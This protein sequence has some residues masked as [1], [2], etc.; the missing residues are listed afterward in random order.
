MPI[1]CQY[2]KNCLPQAQK[3]ET[4]TWNCHSFPEYFSGHLENAFQQ[5]SCLSCIRFSPLLFILMVKSQLTMSRIEVTMRI[6]NIKAIFIKRASKRSIWSIPSATI[7]NCWR[8]PW[9]DDIWELISSFVLCFE[10]SYTIFNQ[11]LPIS[12]GLS[13]L[14]GLWIDDS[15]DCGN[16]I[17]LLLKPYWSLQIHLACYTN[18]QFSPKRKMWRRSNTLGERFSSGSLRK[19]TN[20]RHAVT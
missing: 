1:N 7:K 6:T 13:G 20:H 9:P 15:V 5:N 8:T 16:D 18:W 3:H 10:M 11:I 2:C 14:L 19:F 12:F 4:L 17:Q